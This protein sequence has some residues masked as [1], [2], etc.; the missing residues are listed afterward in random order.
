MV[1]FNFSLGNYGDDS[2]IYH[3]VNSG[4]GSKKAVSN[5][6]Q[7]HHSRGVANDNTHICSP[8]NGDDD[9]VSDGDELNHDFQNTTITNRPIFLRLTK[10]MGERN[11]FKWIFGRWSDFYMRRL[12]TIRG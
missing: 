10:I 5:S 12:N 2:E 7:V 4:S 6:D 9:S 3:S 1:V 11:A 8:V